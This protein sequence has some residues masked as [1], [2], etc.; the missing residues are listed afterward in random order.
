MKDITE[1]M[2]S[3]HA[4]LCEEADR[5]RM[6]AAAAQSGDRPSWLTRLRD[7]FDGFAPQLLGHIRIEETN[8]YLLP[9]L[10]VRPATSSHV[11]L[12]KREHTE[13]AAT[14]QNIRTFLNFLG[15]D[16]DEDWREC[17][18]RINELLC[19]LERHQQQTSELALL[20]SGQDIN[21][22]D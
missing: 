14:V 8:G 22:G 6:I 19:L 17:N 5:L 1:W 20:A 3:E 11:A 7:C 18:R 16:D 10:E 12:I 9:V 2:H 4:R 15:P 21:I 13:L